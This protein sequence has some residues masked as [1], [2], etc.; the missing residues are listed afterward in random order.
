MMR[1]QQ[2]DR[3]LDTLKAVLRE[4]AEY[5]YH[6]YPAIDSPPYYQAIG[7]KLVKKYKCL[8]HEGVKPWVSYVG[9]C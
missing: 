8:A 6:K 7:E 5:Y 2:N 9:Q 4:T 1:L 3:S